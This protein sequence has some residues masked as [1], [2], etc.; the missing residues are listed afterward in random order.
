MNRE[1]FRVV[2]IRGG[3]LKPI[4]FRLR[5]GEKG[6][7]LFLRTDR[8]NPSAVVEAVRQAGK[9]GDLRPAFFRERDLLDLG[10]TLVRTPGGTPDSE[11]NAAHYEARFP[12]TRR[13]AAW[14]RWRKVHD[15]F[16]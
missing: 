3:P 8:P 12:W 1:F 14:L 13:L 16:N 2:A 11:T 5:E 6:L 10:L 9:Q 7:S 4:E 15:V